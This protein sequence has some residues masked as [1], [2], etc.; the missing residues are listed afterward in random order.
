MSQPLQSQV[1]SMYEQDIC[2]RCERVF[3]AAEGHK[4]NIREALRVQRTSRATRPA[5]F[6]VQPVK[7]VSDERTRAGDW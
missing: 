6:I 2:S 3:S 7:H 4:C 5:R 1:E